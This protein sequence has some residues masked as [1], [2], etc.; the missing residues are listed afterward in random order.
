[1]SSIYFNTLLKIQFSHEFYTDKNC[2]DLKIIPTQSTRNLLERF[3]ILFKNKKN[4]AVLLYE[5]P[6]GSLTMKIKIEK[7][8][9]LIFQFEQINTHFN[10]FT[11]TDSKNGLLK[12]YYFNNLNPVING[13]DHILLNGVALEPLTLCNKLL[14]VEKVSPSSK[15]IIIKD[16]NDQKTKYFFH[17]DFNELKIELTDF[18]FGKY[19]LEQFDDTHNKLGESYT[20]YYSNDLTSSKLFGIFELFI[21]NTYDLSN[22]INHVFNFKSRPIFYR[23]KILK[24]TSSPPVIIDNINASTLLIKH[25]PENPADEILFEAA[26]GS[27]PIVIKSQSLI[28]LKEKG[29]E[30]IRLKKNN[31][32]LIANLPSASANKLENDGSNWFSD[33]YVYVYV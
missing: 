7:Q 28:K 32:T 29:I 11:D 19:T 14:K 23:Y 9:K 12:F 3:G 21:N 16:I 31:E 13:A 26:T 15:Y 24:K 20:F 25:E 17:T 10:I 30:K 1:M 33:I 2:K 4:G 22:P 18:E 8:L 5:S 27:D 6:D